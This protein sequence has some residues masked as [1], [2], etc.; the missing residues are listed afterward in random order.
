MKT[1]YQRTFSPW[2]IAAVAVIVVFAFS[3]CGD[4]D[5]GS[6]TVAVS[7]VELN[8][9]TYQLRM[10][11]TVT[12]TPKILP[13]NASNKNVTWFSSDTAKATVANGVVTPVAEGTSNIIVTTQDG[14]KKAVCVV[15]VIGAGG[16]NIRL[17]TGVSLNEEEIEVVVGL[18]RILTA[19]IEPDNASNKNVT[20]DSSDPSKASVEPGE[21]AGTAI[22]RGVAE[23]TTT[24]TVTTVDGNHTAECEVTVT[25][26]DPDA[27]P[28]TNV[29]VSPKTLNLTLGGTITGNLTAAITPSNATYKG[30]DWTSS[31]TS[32]VTVVNSGANN[33]TGIVTA[34]GEGTATITALT[35]D[36][37]FTDTCAVTVN[38]DPSRVAKVDLNTTTLPLKVGATG[39]LTVTV[40]PNTATN[41]AV[42]WSSSDDEG[43][44]VTLTANPATGV[45]TIKAVG[46]G[47][48]SITVT[49]DADSTKKA[50]CF[51]SVT[52]IS[53]TGVTLS[54]ETLELEEGDFEVLTAIFDPEDATNKNVSWSGSDDDVV[55]VTPSE[56]GSTA[57]IEAVGEGTATITI[58]TE[59]GDFEAE[60]AVT[61]INADP[62]AVLV[63]GVT[64]NKNTLTLPKGS[65]ETLI[66][67]IAPDDATNQNVSWSSDD[68]DVATV[69]SA[70][71]VTAV[72]EGT[73]TITVTTR[74][75]GHK[76]T[77]EVTVPTLVD[78]LTLN[79]TKVTMRRGTSVTLVATVLP[80]EATNKIVEWTTGNEARA[81]VSSAG[82]VSIPNNNQATAGDVTITAKT[83]DGSNLTAT[84][85]VTVQ[86]TTA[87][88]G[89]SV[90]PTTLTLYVGG[91]TGRITPTVLPTNAG[92]RT[93]TWESSDTSVATVSYSTTTNNA[94]ATV[95]PLKV[96]TAILKVTA[97]QV[98]ATNQVWTASCTVTVENPPPVTSILL[99]DDYE[100]YD[101]LPSLPVQYFYSGTMAVV[102]WAQVRPLAALDRTVTVGTSNSAV[103]TAQ[104]AAYDPDEDDTP[105]I[106]NCVGVGNAV[107]TISSVGKMANGQSATNTVTINV[108]PIPVTGVT[109][110]KDSIGLNVGG[111][112]TLSATVS[113]SNATYKTVTWTTSPSGVVSIAV[114]PATGIATVTG[115]AEGTTTITVSSTTDS[116]KKATCEVNVVAVGNVGNVTLNRTTLNLSQRADGTEK[117]TGTL[118]ATVSPESASD[119][120]VSWSIVPAS[121]VATISVDSVT[122]VVT[123]TPVAVGKAT[124]TVS[125]DADPAKTATCAVTVV[126]SMLDDMVKLNPGTFSMGSPGT[127]ANRGSDETVHNVT[128]TQGFYMGKYELTQD[129]WEKVMG[130]YGNYS[131]F[132]IASSQ[133]A[134]RQKEYPVETLNWHETILFCNLLSMR[135]GLSPVYTMYKSDAPEAD[136]IEINDSAM[137]TN[138]E[139][140]PENW[141]TDPADWG[142]VPFGNNYANRRWGF[143]RMV[144]GA[145]GYRLPTEAEWEYA[146]RAG[147]NPKT[148]WN[149]G[150]TNIAGSQAQFD[151][152]TYR[153]QTVPVGMFAPNAWGLYDMHGNVVEWCWDW[154]SSLGTAA[155]TDPK[156]PTG[157]YSYKIIRGGAWWDSRAYLRSACRDAVPPYYDGYPNQSGSLSPVIG[158]RVVRN[159]YTSTPSTKL[160]VPSGTADTQ[161]ERVLPRRMRPANKNSATSIGE[162]LQV[163]RK[164]AIEAIRPE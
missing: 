51:V 89:V 113:P 1:L 38:P 32:V 119:K 123:V 160:T 162:K 39:T 47:S 72:G 116:T 156:G 34:V 41:K 155:V 164:E 60:C 131:Y 82:V 126:L 30:V 69:D 59:D 11:E 161:K 103:V 14:G 61:V 150:S 96:G 16:P 112:E 27:I 81:T 136:G 122:G 86:T 3:G 52:A 132:P 17:V 157:A 67:T 128:L 109:L 133:Y 18:N 145:D 111:T 93:V 139:D 100:E 110:N 23:G 21:D 63:T 57:T 36:G 108:L 50:T 138:W 74:N 15:T 22:V 102:T 127:E 94:P 44:V 85:T 130:D 118:S 142:D 77:C 149:T 158:F 154:Y 98:G 42:T 68:Q 99:W 76:A 55:T 53:V 104:T 13:T 105:I 143:V 4:S 91:A 129:W 84:C 80:E 97:V 24:I 83:T 124:I 140:I 58:I 141:S 79:T 121:G 33:L 148:A 62:N 135:E 45:A 54:A 114:D 147:A 101:Y 66:P 43:K 31:N 7:S 10:G 120:A 28:V 146:C 125:S 152:S 25:A 70:G 65:S 117:V 26:R 35:D 159:Y 37:E 12:L 46:V 95:T 19:I 6:T 56:D 78:S 87:A 40:S 163:I 73:A 8:L 49:S 107:I 134:S 9:A 5:D 90:S 2:A 64:L 92:T 48:A 29:T 115:V 153:N 151:Q 75:G 137:P 20:W 106:I 88:T 71:L 144:D